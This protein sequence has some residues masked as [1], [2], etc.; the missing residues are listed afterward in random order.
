[1][2]KKWTDNENQLKKCLIKY[3]QIF[4]NARADSE[5]RENSPNLQMGLN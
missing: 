2:G 5:N 4:N 1:M 3:E